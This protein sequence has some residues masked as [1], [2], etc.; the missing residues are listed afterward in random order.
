MLTDRAPGKINRCLYLGPARAADGRHELVTV[1]QS[2]TF[3]D[4]VTLSDA[5]GATDDYVVCPGVEGPNIAL[6]ALRAF[7]DATGWDGPPQ[8]IAIIKRVPVAAGMGGGSADA[9]AVL[10]LAARTSG[11]QDA[12]LYALAAGLGADVPAQV[13]PGRAL[14][15]GAGEFVEPLQ[16]GPPFGV[17]ILPGPRPLLTAAVFAEADRLGLVRDADDLA[18]REAEV[19]A[20]LQR[21][22][23]PEPHNDLEAAAISLEPEIHDRLG[24]ARAAGA[25]HAM[26]S[27]SGPTVLG[28][29]LGED[30]PGDSRRAAETIGGA[31]YG[32]GVTT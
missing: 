11:H 22:E 4:A 23:D 28:L 13:R 8:R 32:E 21:E 6:D 7:R 29:F 24:V 26:V 18:A 25:D 15:L 20:A 2:V 31:H 3:A 10:R 19:R 16:P 1:M 17:L 27:G 12:D 14:A 9:A 30:G 5:P